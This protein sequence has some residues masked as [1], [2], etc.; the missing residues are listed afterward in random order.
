MLTIYRRHQPPCEKTSRRFRT[1]GCAIWVQGTLAGESVR[2]SMKTRSWDRA[3]KLVHEWEATGQVGGR[4][5]EIP[6]IP[7]AVDKYL[8]D[9][10]A[11][12][13]KESSL[14]KYRLF[15]RRQFLPWCEST[16]RRHL[17]QLGVEAMREFRESW[18]FAPV[19][20]MKKLE[21]LRAFMR[22]CQASEWMQSNPAAALRPPKVTS[23]P[24][25]PFDE[26]EVK[27]LLDA[28]AKFNGNGDRLRAMI[29]LLRYSGLRIS[30]GVALKR[31]RVLAGKIFLYTQKTG[32]PVW[33]PVPGK[34]T[35]ALKKMPGE[36]Y[37]FWSGNGKPKSAIED[38]RRSFMLL[39]ELADVKKARFHRFRDSFAVSLLEQGVS[40][41]HVAILLG[42]TPAIVLKHYRPWVKSLQKNLEKA[43]RAAW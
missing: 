22:F 24:T 15:L 20:Q 41:E 9:C 28:C 37:V 21:C 42:N 10:Q 25:L 29:L 14:K 6:M 3:S 34:V 39:A 1:C 35:A 30:D 2:Q 38:V 16:G 31:E 36:E 23:P 7:G 33:V 12:G 13:L 32:T 5:V 26:A 4:Q 17:R 18:K 8:A 11:R 43:V 19:T 40:V 27:K